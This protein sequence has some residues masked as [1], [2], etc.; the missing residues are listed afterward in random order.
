MPILSE[1]DLERFRTKVC[2]LASSM[3]C[4]FGVERCNYSHNLYWARRCPFYLRDSSILRY[5]PACCPD[6]ELGPGSAILKNTCPRGNNCA[7]AHSLE[8]MNYHPLVYK[9]KMCA[10]YREG[11]CRTYYCHLVHGLAEYRVPRDYVLPRKRGI[12]IPQFEHVTMVDNIRNSQGNVNSCGYLRDKS[13]KMEHELR[14]SILPGGLMNR[15]Q[16][17]QQFNMSQ[18]QLPCNFQAYNNG[19]G[20][21]KPNAYVTHNPSHAYSGY[22][23][24]ASF[25]RG[26]LATGT[27]YKN[28]SLMDSIGCDASKGEPCEKLNTIHW[29]EDVIESLNKS[30][31]NELKTSSQYS[32][33]FSEDHKGESCVKGNIEKGKLANKVKDYAAQ[34]QVTNSVEDP[35]EGINEAPSRWYDNNSNMVTASEG[36]TPKNSITNMETM[37]QTPR[38]E[39]DAF[40]SAAANDNSPCSTMSQIYN[41]FGCPN[42][43][44]NISGWKTNSPIPRSLSLQCVSE[45]GANSEDNNHKDINN[46]L[47]EYV[48]HTV[49]QQCELIAGKCVQ[50]PNNKA[51]LQ[52]ICN[53]AHSLWQLLL[54]IQTLLYESDSN[55]TVDTADPCQVNHSADIVERQWSDVDS[56]YCDLVDAYESENTHTSTI[57]T[58]ATDDSVKCLSKH[59]E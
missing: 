16:P 47:L 38:E 26:V 4:D 25:Q 9:T 51:N 55:S 2:S 27:I 24:P 54:S 56:F 14:N 10:Q 12:N 17:S 20:E 42:V 3:R 29:T 32:N 5:I 45:E 30:T 13:L 53:D 23:N 34:L 19:Q 31:A 6:V 35:K 49:S 22:H 15:S 57:C 46:N 36:R 18:P 59:A 58:N 7:F 28:E 11:N 40:N 44:R 43:V 50:T 37:F 41:R 1:E 52:S 39:C 8:E 48:Y 21:S 33:S